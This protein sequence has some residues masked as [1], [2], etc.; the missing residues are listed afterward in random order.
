MEVND[1]VAAP[2]TGVGL[3]EMKLD[4]GRLPIHVDVNRNLHNR[5]EP[6]EFSAA[7][8]TGYYVALWRHD[9]P[10]IVTGNFGALSARPSRRA[11][12]ITLLETRSLAEFEAGAFRKPIDL[13]KLMI[14][15]AVEQMNA[16]VT[17]LRA[18]A[19]SIKLIQA[20]VNNPK[21]F[22][23]NHWPQSASKN[24][25]TNNPGTEWQAE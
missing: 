1:S 23:D 24:F 4:D 21:G 16:L 14:N 17:S 6:P 18:T 20:S 15:N 3:F 5:L 9:A 11:E 12:I 25:D 22:K 2:L 7:A 10:T 8:K 13:L 19:N